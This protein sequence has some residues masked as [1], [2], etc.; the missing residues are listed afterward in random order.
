MEQIISKVW[1]LHGTFGGSTPGVLML[2]DGKVSFTTEEGEHFNVPV[3]EVKDVKWPFISFGMALNV[4]ING[5]K[6]KFSF[7]RPNGGA[8]IGD[9]T[10]TQIGRFTSVGRGMDAVTS[11]AKWGDTKKTSKQ[12]KEVLK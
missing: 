1:L 4:A 12:W 2:N 10:L 8:D 3:S 5:Q 7:M 9:S 11:L 6:Y